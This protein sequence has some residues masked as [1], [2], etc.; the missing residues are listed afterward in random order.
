MQTKRWEWEID[1]N[2]F[3]SV[4]FNPD[5]TFKLSAEAIKSTPLYYSHPYKVHTDAGFDLYSTAKLTSISVSL[6]P[7][8]LSMFEIRLSTNY[9]CDFHTNPTSINTELWPVLSVHILTELKH[10]NLI[11]SFNIGL[12]HIGF[13]ISYW[14][15]M[16]IHAGLSSN[17]TQH[18]T[19]ACEV[20]AHS[21]KKLNLQLHIQN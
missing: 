3:P 2:R 19:L 4:Q 8:E 16:P 18:Y 20:Q 1:S 21:H 5:R 7:R 10:T 9:G 12:S 14:A 15:W 17:H 11:L 13:T 6:F